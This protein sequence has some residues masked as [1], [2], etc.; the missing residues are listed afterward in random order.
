MMR[1]RTDRIKHHVGHNLLAAFLYFLCGF[2]M[3]RL[4]NVYGYSI[5][6]FAPAGFALGAYLCCGVRILPGIGLGSL[7]F[8]LFLWNSMVSS[9]EFTLAGFLPVALVIAFGAVIQT[10]TGGLLLQSGVGSINPLDRIRDVLVFIFGVGA[11]NS[12]IHST[13]AQ[14]ALMVGGFL[15]PGQFGS[16]WITWWLGDTMGVLTVTPLF[17]VYLSTGSFKLHRNQAVEAV[18]LAVIFYLASQVVFGNLLN[19]WHYPLVYL[20]FPVLVWAAFRFRQPGA[21]IAILMVSLVAIWG[22]AQG[23][24]PMALRTLEESLR[25]LQFYLLVL[26]VMTLILTASISET[27]AA[28]KRSTS[29]GR[30]LENS[31][32]EIYVFDAETLKFIQVNLGARH[33][34]GY[35]MRELEDLTPLDL[36]PH[37]TRDK[38]VKMLDPL[39]G[40][41]Q[42][43]VFESRH[44]RKYRTEYPVEVRI[45]Y[46]EMA[47][48]PVY[49]AIVQDITEKKRAEE[50]LFKY[51]HH[52]E[53]LV[54]QR[55]ADLESAHRQLMHAEKL[56]ATGKLAASMAHEFNNP[57][58]GI[59]SVLEKILRRSNLQSKDRDFVAL[60]IKECD[61]ISTLIKKLLDFHSPSTDQKEVFNFH[62]AVED[63]VFLVKKKM[64]EKNIQLI[65]NYSPDVKNVEAVPDQIRQVILNLLQNAEEA[66]TPKN[67][68][69]E[70]RTALEGG[71]IRLDIADSGQGIPADVMKNI[72]DPFFTTKPSVKGTGLGLSVSYGIVKNHGGD[73]QAASTPG[74][75]ATFTVLIPVKAQSPSRDVLQSPALMSFNNN[76]PKQSVPRP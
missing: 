26:T 60:A 36:M 69:I 66:I 25:L 58:Y 24:G 18:A 21:V 63:M 48:R 57:I 46:S 70:I 9:P 10:V 68:T 50:E 4:A 45:Q 41:L 30:I 53:E 34:L 40:E 74:Q 75:G 37:F 76:T 47:S 2:G 6:L 14:T 72:F 67:G 23:R 28:D 12:T 42:Q 8:T 5:P 11:L 1:L 62:E 73:I 22:T 44:K 29:F 51:R 27:A 15:P 49:F 32:N 16:A 56:S 55:T 19:Y 65:R 31:S 17:M 43:I 3:V 64:K 54:E 35:S 7:G 20:L 39:R 13:I 59:H 52:L 71:T 38:F 61:R 33:N